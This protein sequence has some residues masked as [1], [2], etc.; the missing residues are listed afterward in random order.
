MRRILVA[1]IFLPIV[2]A[3]Q[4][5]TPAKE[6]LAVVQNGKYGYI[7]HAGEVVIRPQFVW[8]SDFHQGFATV[9]LCGRLVSITES[10]EIGPLKYLVG[11]A[12]L[13]PDKEGDK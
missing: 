12:G 7:N 10:G 5:N 8:G 1:A 3:G 9:Y 6:P 4:E 13:S 11:S 2:A